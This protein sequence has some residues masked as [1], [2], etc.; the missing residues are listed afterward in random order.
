LR[1]SEIGCGFKLKDIRNHSVRNPLAIF[2]PAW[3]VLFH[4]FILV[5]VAAMPMEIRNPYIKK[6]IRLP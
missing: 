1:H 5:A 2:S 6:E 3:A 4:T